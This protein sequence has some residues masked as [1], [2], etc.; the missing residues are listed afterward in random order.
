M[1]NQVT[2]ACLRCAFLVPGG[3]VSLTFSELPLAERLPW[4]HIH[5][6]VIIE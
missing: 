3:P 2:G 4:P 1:G 6:T 5:I